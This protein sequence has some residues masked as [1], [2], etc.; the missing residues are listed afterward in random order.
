[1]NIHVKRALSQSAE[2]FRSIVWPSIAPHIGGGE[3]QPVESVTAEG[4]T[5]I[6]DTLSGI[7]AWQV[8]DGQGV[9]GIAS[10]VQRDKDDWGTFTIR[11]KTQRGSSET[12]F[13]KIERITRRCKLGFLHAGLVVQAYLRANLRMRRDPC[14]YVIRAHEFY[15]LVNAETRGTKLRPGQVSSGKLWYE[16]SCGHGQVMAVF[17]VAAL[18]DAGCPVL[19]VSCA[20]AAA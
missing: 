5:K 2:D 13:A 12:E 19:R 8:I 4:F 1:M 11:L 10:R 9:R 17:P 6:L 15:P 18:Q 14:A 3:L 16:Q 7:D 20:E